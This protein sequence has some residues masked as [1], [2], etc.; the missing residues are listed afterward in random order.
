LDA[1]WTNLGPSVAKNVE[2]GFEF[3]VGVTV[4]WSAAP[5]WMQQACQIAAWGVVCQLANPDL[6]VGQVIS[7]SNLPVTLS[8]DAPAGDYP[9]TDF[10][11]LAAI[12]TD[13]PEPDYANNFLTADLSIGQPE[14]D[15]SLTKT[16]ISA[17][18]VMAGDE[19]TYRLELKNQG[20]AT[21]TNVTVT[22]NVPAGLT[23][24]SVVADGGATCAL[25]SQTGDLVCPFGVVKA[26][27]TRSVTVTFAIP[28]DY[29]SRQ[30]RNSAIVTAPQ[31]D[32]HPGDNTP[33]TN[34]RVVFPPATDVGVEVTTDQT[35]VPA[36]SQVEF[37]VTVTNY[38]PEDTDGVNLT[39]QLSEKLNALTATPVGLTSR[40]PQAEPCQ[41]G[42]DQLTMTCWI[43]PMPAQSDLV[44]RFTVTTTDQAGYTDTLTGLVTHYQIDTNPANNSS[45][46]SVL[47]VAP[48]V[49]PEPPVP[50]GP[51]PPVPPAP[52]PE[53]VPPTPVT[54]PIGPFG[55]P[56]TQTTVTLT[57]LLAAGLI[58]L[59]VVLMW[60]SRRRRPI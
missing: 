57:L 46:A 43:G 28:V 52:E 59:G 29:A 56:L 36:G 9:G 6:A 10:G 16:L 1:T 23:L 32:P 22:D 24:V 33:E 19:L 48:P 53:P 58:G 3:P 50:P 18:P 42:A 11:T 54:P 41:V 45:A 17:D 31:T 39:L 38:G 14:A 27:E 34:H 8:G 44:Y 7:L 40:A 21:A 12:S 26:D 5:S 2:F 47:T 15:L 60:T 20:P 51:E 49:P 30:V 13:T 35:T 4:D 55:L 25:D 37:Q